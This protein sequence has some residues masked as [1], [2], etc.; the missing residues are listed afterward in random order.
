MSAIAME[1][2]PRVRRH[3]P[4]RFASV[5]S[6]D[7]RVESDQIDHQESAS[8]L[9]MGSYSVDV[10]PGPSTT[11]PALAATHETACTARPALSEKSTPIPRDKSESISGRTRVI[12]GNVVDGDVAHDWECVR[13]L[14][15]LSPS[16][17]ADS[18]CGIE[19]WASGCISYADIVGTWDDG[20]D[21]CEAKSWTSDKGDDPSHAARRWD[22]IPEYLKSSGI[23]K[24]TPFLRMHGRP[25]DSRRAPPERSTHRSARSRTLDAVPD[26]R[27]HI[28]LLSALVS[29]LSIDDE[30]SHLVTHLPAHSALFPGPINPSD[31]EIEKA[32]EIHGVHV[33]LSRH[34]ALREGLAVACDESVLSSNPFRLSASPLF[35]LLYIV[36]GL[37]VGGSATLN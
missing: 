14:R 24:D 35:G 29:L 10:L 11:P 23:R 30:T 26:R 22:L 18:E 34:G 3:L 16:A 5:R 6:S 27:I 21:E 19:D 37:F 32:Q 7:S 17:N 36:R 9:S 4:T 20:D 28:P 8:D 25:L 33:L 31:E 12:P 13:S 1:Y 15:Q 2:G